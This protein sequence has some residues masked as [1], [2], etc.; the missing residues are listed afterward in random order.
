MRMIENW[1]QTK[2]ADDKYTK[3]IEEFSN[4]HVI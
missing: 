1:S 3:Y 2:V 4:N